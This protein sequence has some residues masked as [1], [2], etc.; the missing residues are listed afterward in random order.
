MAEI[1]TTIEGL[2]GESPKKPQKKG[3]HPIVY[4]GTGIT[5][6]TL[7]VTY[8]LDKTGVIDVLSMTIR[9]IHDDN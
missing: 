5:I 3:I 4:V 2:V 6:L 8:V 1:N 7:G 9:N